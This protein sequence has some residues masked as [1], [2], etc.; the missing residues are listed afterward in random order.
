LR[1]RVQSSGLRSHGLEHRVQGL[2]FRV[3]SLRFRV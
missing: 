2:G 3:S 1:S